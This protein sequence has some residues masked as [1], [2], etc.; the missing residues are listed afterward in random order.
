MGRNYSWF[1]FFKSFRLKLLGELA[2]QAAP[3]N[4]ERPQVKWGN[5]VAR[6]L[7][8]T[9]DPGPFGHLPAGVTPQM[10]LI[11]PTMAPFP[12]LWRCLSC[13]PS[14]PPTQLGHLG[15]GCGRAILKQ[16][17]WFSSGFMALFS[18]QLLRICPRGMGSPSTFLGW[19]TFLCP[20][21]LL[22][23]FLPSELGCKPG[24]RNLKAEYQLDSG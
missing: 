8:R 1:I 17:L 5:W 20:L 21:A 6:S 10:I 16:T 3:W 18:P 22:W 24:A 19:Q 2:R 4:P 23:I 14:A 11:T 13:A 9:A 15:E 12:E 7:E